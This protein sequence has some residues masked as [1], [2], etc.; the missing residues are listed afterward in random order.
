MR[1]LSIQM[2]WTE[3][4]TKVWFI[5]IRI[6]TWCVDFTSYNEIGVEGI[7]GAKLEYVIQK[8]L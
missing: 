2:F 7:I 1:N 3:Q 6:A 5:T 4:I 8:V